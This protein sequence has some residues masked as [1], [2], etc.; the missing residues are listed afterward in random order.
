M[1]LEVQPKP[2]GLSRPGKSGAGLRRLAAGSWRILRILALLGLLVWAGQRA[3]QHYRAEVTAKTPLPTIPTARA[4]RGSLALR[5]AGNGTLEAEKTYVVANQQVES[6]IVD[7]VEDGAMVKEGAVIVQ[8]D[9]GKIEKEIS[10]Q[11]TSHE[12]ALAQIAKADAEGKLQVANA[13]MKTR[14]AQEEQSLLA[15]TNRSQIDQVS[16]ELDFN[17]AELKQSERQRERKKGL[18]SD[19]LIPVREAELAELQVAKGSLNVT[20]GER[21]LSLQE[22]QE[23]A[24]KTQGELLVSDARYSEQVARNKAEEQVENANFNAQSTARR[25]ELLRLQ[26]TWCTVRAP[27]S[28]LTVL[29]RE[30][31][32]GGGGQRPLRPGDT[33]FPSRRL[34][35]IIDLTKMRVVTEV[36]EID[37]SRVSVGQEVLIR[38]R[39]APDTLLH[40]QV[41]S[42]SS[43]ARPGDVWRRNAIPGKKTFRMVIAVKESRPDLL[44]PGM[45]VDYEVVEKRLE[46]VVTVPI[47]A[48]QKSARGPAVFVRRG[49]Q[50]VA[51]PV[52]TG[53]RNDNRVTITRGLKGGETIAL[54][55]PPL[56]LIQRPAAKKPAG[57][58]PRPTKSGPHPPTPSPKNER[59]GVTAARQLSPPLPKLGEGVG[60]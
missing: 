52:T 26:R 30:W 38:P 32:G 36:S 49:R 11:L 41:R 42:I 22:H 23:R 43:L 56:S 14:K 47:Q 28:G 44:R 16:S 21:K 13:A 5:L 55:R 24:S 35:D 19:R 33:A 57:S 39:S 51:K 54:Q 46:G 40:G 34:M 6:Q 15:A 20:Q 12:Q 7:I 2:E 31:D 17:R 27:A 1:A 25:L 18:A 3:L 37:V 58:G 4:T 53:L 10:T 60:G 29:A 50:F 59:G 9:T 48:V 8:L 45:T